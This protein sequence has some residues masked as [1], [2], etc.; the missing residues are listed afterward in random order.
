MRYLIEQD[1]KPKAGAEAFVRGFKVSDGILAVR[2]EIPSTKTVLQPRD[3]D[4][5]PLWRR[6]PRSR[7]PR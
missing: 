7:G 4:G 2:V 3:E 6:G 1:F 5:F